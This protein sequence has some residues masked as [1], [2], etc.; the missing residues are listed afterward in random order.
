MYIKGIA[1]IDNRTKN[2]VKRLLPNEIAIINHKDLDEVAARSLVEAKVQAVI[3]AAPSLSEDYPNPGPLI[4]V[5]AGIHVIDNVGTEVMTD[6]IEGQE[7]EIHFNQIFVNGKIISTGKVLTKEYITKKM[8]ET[9]KHISKVLAKFVQNTLQYAQNEVGMILGEVKIPETKTIFKNKHTLIVVRGKNYKE[10]LIAIKSYINEVKPVLVGVDGGAD[11]LREFG[12]QPDLIIGDMDSITD[13]TLRCGAELIVHAYP[14]GKAPGLQRL[15]EMG[16]SAKT[17][18][19][20][21]TSED[22]AMLLAYEQGT[23]L[24]VAVGTHSNMYDFLEKGRKGMASTFLVRLKVGSILIDA[25]GVSK[26]YKNKIKARYLA[27]IFLAALLPFTIILVISPATRELLRL[28]FIQFRLIL[29][30]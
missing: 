26:L 1:K 27:Q 6:I 5:E 18:P 10:D 29:G 28:L 19:A 13:Q 16:L 11:A 24:I 9:E 15:N 2:L 20:P 4:L 22:I 30:I 7:V 23:D 8:A 12:Y 25:K 17:F 3:N 14:D 21:G